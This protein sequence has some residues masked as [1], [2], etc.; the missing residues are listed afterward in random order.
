M[1]QEL[2]KRLIEEALED[3]KG[4]T[5]SMGRPKRLWNAL[6]GRIFVGVSCNLAEPVYNCY[7]DAPPDG[8]LFDE[9]QR[10]AERTRDQV[11]SER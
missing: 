11:P 1:D 7:Q 2:Q 5:D 10:R 9:L 4:A 6:E 3:T 8:G